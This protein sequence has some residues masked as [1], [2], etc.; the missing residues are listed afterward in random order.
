LTDSFDTFL[1]IS[2]ALT[3]V[4]AVCFFLTGRVKPV[5]VENHDLAVAHEGSVRVAAGDEM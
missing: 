2:A 4:G 3:L 5:S 1:V